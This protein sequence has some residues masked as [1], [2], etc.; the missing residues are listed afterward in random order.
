MI[1][2]S[3]PKE[4]QDDLAEKFKSKRK[5]MKHSRANAAKLSGVPEPTIRR[6]EN[7]GEISFRQFLMLCNTYGDLSIYTYS[8]SKPPARTMDELIKLNKRKENL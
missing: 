4:L 7:T 6:F 8:F 1:S 3:S 2:I 5:W